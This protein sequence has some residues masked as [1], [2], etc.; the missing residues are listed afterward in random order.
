MSCINLEYVEI[1]KEYTINKNMFLPCLNNEYGKRF[2]SS[3]ASASYSY[4]ATSSKD[5]G[6]EASD[7]VIGSYTAS[8]NYTLAVN[9]F[10]EFIVDYDMNLSMNMNGNAS[11]TYFFEDGDSCN[12][13]IKTNKKWTSL[14]KPIGC[15]G[16][17]I[18]RM[19]IQGGITQ[20]STCGPAQNPLEVCDCS[21][22]WNE[23]LPPSSANNPGLCDTT[24]FAGQNW[25]ACF[26]PQS[27]NSCSNSSSYYCGEGCQVCGSVSIGTSSNIN[28]SSE[29][30]SSELASF[31]TS[32]LQKQLKIAAKN[33]IASCRTYEENLEDYIG[34]TP[35]CLPYE[36][37]D[38]CWSLPYPD[39]RTIMQT[40]V[41]QNELNEGYGYDKIWA[42]L[43]LI[44]KEYFLKRYKKVFGKVFFYIPIESNSL[45]PCC[46]KEEFL[47]QGGIIIKQIPFT[48]DGKETFNNIYVCPSRR[49]GNLNF[50][51][52][53]EAQAYVGENM[54]VCF[55]I[56]EIQ[57]M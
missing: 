34:G 29:I 16:K 19:N 3:S 5:C 42:V 54:S 31:C 26:N 24:C 15:A 55:K 7:I 23:E 48:I 51:L 41:E 2:K 57:S 27:C 46:D 4:N 28:V 44:D 20:N 25:T 52:D 49:E 12:T 32:A 30:S 43:P 22:T 38:S 18:A 6:P 56:D 40:V 39:P 33:E 14:Y 17:N 36:S 47:S 37:K 8:S 53:S 21:K 50:V 45:T 13:L 9:E 11:Y 1:L 10:G 35:G